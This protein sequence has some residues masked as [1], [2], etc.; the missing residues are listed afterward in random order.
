MRE[1]S[2]RLRI[3]VHNLKPVKVAYA[4]ESAY[5]GHLT[6]QRHAYGPSR[7]VL[8]DH[9]LRTDHEALSRFGDAARRVLMADRERL[10]ALGDNRAFLTLRDQRAARNRLRKN[11]ATIEGTFID[12]ER[13]IA[14]YDHAI[15]RT[16]IETPGV[17][18][19]DV[20]GSLNHLRDRAASL[21]Y[22]LSQAYQVAE[23]HAQ[24]PRTGGEPPL[25]RRRL[26]RRGN[27]PPPPYPDPHPRAHPTS[28]PHRLIP[29]KK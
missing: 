24:Q 6:S 25:A 21:H 14:S 3:Q 23:G 19:A 26:L 11:F 13:R 27:T 20:E 15:D 1:A 18:L 10:F 17:S 8:L 28:E 2:Y 7:A 22:E 4:P 12:L 9:E 29:E 16:R 5:A